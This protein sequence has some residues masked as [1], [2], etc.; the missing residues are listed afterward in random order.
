MDQLY[1]IVD[2]LLLGNDFV[3]GCRIVDVVRQGKLL[4]RVPT[5]QLSS[6]YSV[7]NAI[8][9]PNV[10]LLLGQ[11]LFFVSLSIPLLIA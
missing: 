9:R 7:R 4:P 3:T 11:L 6:W 2:A 5:V 1:Q 10:R 8:Q